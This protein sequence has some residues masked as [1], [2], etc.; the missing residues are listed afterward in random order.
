MP[1]LRFLISGGAP[2]PETLGV[3]VREAGIRFRQGYGLT[4]CGPNCFAITDDEALRRPGAVG[5]PSRRDAGTTL[6]H[7]GDDPSAC[8]QVAAKSRAK[9]ATAR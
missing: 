4:E 7:R 8:S 1:S 5:W 6:V 2:C 9:S 3:R